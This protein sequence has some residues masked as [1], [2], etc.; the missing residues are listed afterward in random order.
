MKYSN[1]LEFIGRKLRPVELALFTKWL[2]RIKRQEHTL[3][4]ESKFYID[5][6]SEFGLKLMRN[7]SYETDMTNQV[8]KVL[9]PGDIFVDLGANEGFFSIVGSKIV[10]K[11][12]QVIA[13]E[14]QQRLWE[15]IVKNVEI[16]GLSNVMLLPYGIGSSNGEAE[17]H[18]YPNLNSGASSLAKSFNFKVS[19]RKFRKAIYSTSKIT[20]KTLD[21]IFEQ[22]RNIKLMKVDI[23]GFELEALKG[24]KQLL[25]NHTI[26]NL[27]IEIHPEALHSLDQSEKEIENLLTGHGYTKR[28]IAKNLVLYSLSGKSF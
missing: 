23:E 28:D 8:Q 9:K 21:E 3:P 27:L 2:L 20:I 25:G 18:F 11:E 19:L 6:I 13:V 22:G 10:G 15:I 24:A 7:N 1:K 14:P 5:P 26:Q 4:D 17:M 12:G 16:N